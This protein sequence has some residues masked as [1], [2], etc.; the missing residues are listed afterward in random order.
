M[1]FVMDATGQCAYVSPEWTHFTGQ[2]VNDALASGWLSRVYPDDRQAVA[3]IIAAATS[4]AAEFSCRY[5]LMRPDNTPRWVGA[6]GVPSF[7]IEEGRF[8]GY[9]GSIT[10]LAEGALDTIQAYG[11]V[12][13]F[14][15]PAPHPATIPGDQIDRIADYLILAHSLIEDDGA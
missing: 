1:I 3:G 2:P 7:G 15:P 8:I 12:G 11:N 4:S 14:V 9:L 10:E 13:R 5:R 6:G